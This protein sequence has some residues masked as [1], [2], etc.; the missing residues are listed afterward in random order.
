[1]TRFSA[2]LLGM[3]RSDEW[4]ILEVDTSA[5]TDLGRAVSQSPVRDK[6]LRRAEEVGLNPS[7]C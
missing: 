1:M 2:T 6:E 4:T 5:Q 3:A 7:M